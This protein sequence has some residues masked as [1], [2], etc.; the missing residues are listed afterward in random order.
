VPPT[1]GHARPSVSKH[2][3]GPQ[4]GNAIGGPP[5]SPGRGIVMRGGSAADGAAP[6][7]GIGAVAE[8]TGSGAPRA[9]RAAR[10]RSPWRRIVA[11]SSADGGVVEVDV[12]V[13]CVGGVETDGGGS[14]GTSA[15]GG[16]SGQSSHGGRGA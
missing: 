6:G 2:P 5:G 14:P 13:D 11:D 9:R 12:G 15:R 1:W 16:S 10:S 7:E 8:G 3:A 4:V